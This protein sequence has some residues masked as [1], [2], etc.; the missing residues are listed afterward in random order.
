M[1]P[2]YT[3][4][5]VHFLMG[6]DYL[7]A[8][9]VITLTNSPRRARFLEELHT[10]CPSRILHIL[11]DEGFRNVPRE[12]CKQE[13]VY[14][15]NLAHRQ[16]MLHA[17]KHYPEMCVAI[18]EDDFFWAHDAH[19]GLRN[20][21]EYVKSNAHHVTHYCMGGIP[22]PSVLHTD[23]L[24]GRQHARHPAVTSHAMI[25]TPK[26]MRA[27]VRDYTLLCPEAKF[28]DS[29][30][31]KTSHIYHR[32]LAYQLFPQ[33]HNQMNSWPRGL[34]KVARLLRA[35]VSVVPTYPLM[36]TLGR[37]VPALAVALVVVLVAFLVHLFQRYYTQGPIQT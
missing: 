20:A 21:C 34:V 24:L 31:S 30:F 4:E 8:S 36:Y 29:Y 14:D 23:L 25:H 9:Y 13:P 26:G 7:M 35:D 6:K 22:I 2:G 28:L 1:D 33:T 32:P 19:D 10:L 15:I 18:F 3:F 37:I 11:N 16:A 12:L 5:T 17:Q 27:F